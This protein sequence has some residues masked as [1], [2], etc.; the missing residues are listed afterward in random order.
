MP[1]SK[2]WFLVQGTLLHEKNIEKCNFKQHYSEAVVL[3]LNL[4][5][6]S[7]IRLKKN[8][9]PY[10][11][12]R[13]V[14]KIHDYVELIYEGGEDHVCL[15]F[16]NLSKIHDEPEILGYNKFHRLVFNLCLYIVNATNL[17]LVTLFPLYLALKNQFFLLRGCYQ[18]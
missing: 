1:Q 16:M 10:N 18:L 12:S 14:F 6:V 9:E 2:N 3:R 4:K 7:W 17:I 5:W 15:N 13:K 11:C 8:A